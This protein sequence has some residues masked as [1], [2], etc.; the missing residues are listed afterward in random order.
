MSGTLL[1][2]KYPQKGVLIKS[3]IANG[4]SCFYCTF[5]GGLNL[6]PPNEHFATKVSR[7]SL[8]LLM[9][10]FNVEF[11]NSSTYKG[12]SWPRK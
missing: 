10:T 12:Y 7:R 6:R 1:L 3:P 8:L 11:N 9:L 5:P 4:A 2:H